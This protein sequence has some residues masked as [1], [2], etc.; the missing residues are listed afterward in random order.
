MS[1]RGY[2]PGELF[3]RTMLARVTNPSRNDTEC[4]EE[5]QGN[6]LAAEVEQVYDNVELTAEILDETDGPAD[7]VPSTH[8]NACGN[9]C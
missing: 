2:K 6:S 8:P 4:Q 5:S 7:G 3:R 9:P 1:S